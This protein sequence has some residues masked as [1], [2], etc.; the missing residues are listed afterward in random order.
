MEDY[1]KNLVYSIDDPNSHKDICKLGKAL[2]SD[3]RIKILGI[4]QKQAKY[5]IELSNELSIPLAT[6]SRHIDILAAAKLIYISY[7]PGPKGHSKLCAQAFYSA[8]VHY[9]AEPTDNN[10]A[11]WITEMPIGLYSN[12]SIT[13]PCGMNG[14][15]APLGQFDNP[16]VFYSAERTNAELIWFTTGYLSYLL[17]Y[18]H[19]KDFKSTNLN[20]SF[21]ICSETVY[22]RNKWPS[23]ITVI[24]NDIEIH[25]FTSPGD[26]GG[27][28]G[29]FTPDFWPEMSTQYGILMSFTINENGVYVNNIFIHDKVKIKDLYL[30]KNS[31]VK[32]MLTIKEDAIYKGGMNLF[33][34]NFGDY[35][36]AIVMTI[37]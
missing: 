30:E 9:T 33:G 13:A 31:Y 12:C 28:R 32:F 1:D 37:K 36:Q 14:K 10:D 15:T 27:R 21:E 4:L 24:I 16:L 35:N 11:I 29:K 23:D 3:D 34:K 26:F 2:S 20:I 19:S 25:T 5:M 8:T 7:S 6:V 22:H 17:P 18:Q